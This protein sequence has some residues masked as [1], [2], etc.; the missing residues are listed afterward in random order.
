MKPLKA[1]QISC[2]RTSDILLSWKK[3]IVFLSYK[4]ILKWSKLIQDPA[5]TL[6]TMVEPWLTMVGHDNMVRLSQGKGPIHKNMYFSRTKPNL[7]WLQLI[8]AKLLPNVS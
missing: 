1:S 6:P 8:I 3:N 4:S 5:V 2:S 7:S